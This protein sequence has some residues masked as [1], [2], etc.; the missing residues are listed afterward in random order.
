MIAARV[1]VTLRSKGGELMRPGA[2]VAVLLLAA[3]G[4]VSPSSTVSLSSPS[5]APPTQTVAA[6]TPRP[7]ASTVG[8][9]VGLVAQIRG[10]WSPNPIAL[11]PAAMALVD[12]ACRGLLADLQVGSELTIVEARGD[13]L[14]SAFYA[15]TTEFA[16]CNGM[17]V[18]PSGQI[19]D[20]M[21]GTR[22]PFEDGFAVG[23]TDVWTADS[24]GMDAPIPAFFLAGRAGSEIA[25]VELPRPGEPTI[26][27]ALANGWF[28]M[29]SPWSPGD[30]PFVTIR[31]LDASGAIVVEG[32]P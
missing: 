7:G 15:G 1:R 18:D 25:R 28:A 29:W 5:A 19:G 23:A 16:S 9:D 8:L 13:G 11:P 17:S 3:C 2:L 12:Q 10:P 30:A 4:T 21:F 14:V 32:D 24:T 20:L 22:K 27:A 6:P 31:G 26:V